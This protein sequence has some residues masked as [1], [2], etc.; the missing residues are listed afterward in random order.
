MLR[1]LA[2]DWSASRVAAA[3]A[4]VLAPAF[5]AAPAA[6]STPRRA[7]EMALS[8]LRMATWPKTPALLWLAEMLSLLLTPSRSGRRGW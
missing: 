6:C 5:S 2:L 4:L 1:R 3:V 7:L 8:A